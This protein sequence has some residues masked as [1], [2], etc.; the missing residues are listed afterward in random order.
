MEEQIFEDPY[1]I[2]LEVSLFQMLFKYSII[3]LFYLF[4]ILDYDDT[5]P[6]NSY[7]KIHMIMMYNF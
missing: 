4:S 6:L 3:F 5:F 7:G 2:I 1:S